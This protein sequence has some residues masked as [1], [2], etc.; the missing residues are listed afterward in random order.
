M[1]DPVGLETRSVQKMAEPSDEHRWH[2]AL[3]RL[4]PEIV[5]AKPESLP[6]NAPSGIPTPEA[7]TAVPPEPVADPT[8]HGENP[9]GE[10]ENS[11]LQS[12]RYWAA[13]AGVAGVIAAL[14]GLLALL[15]MSM[16]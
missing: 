3:E 7:G 9:T 10:A 16:R 14:T 15:P 4:G 12:L 13:V 1:A 2:E 8:L 5:R 6:E 11:G